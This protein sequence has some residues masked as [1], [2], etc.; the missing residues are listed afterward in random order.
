VAQTLT[1]LVA[2]VTADVPA[3]N[4]VPSSG[5]YTQAVK[6]AVDAYSLRNPIVDTTTLS[7]VADTADY[8]LPSD[9]IVEIRMRA[10]EL[11]DYYGEEWEIKGD[12]TV[13][14]YP[15]PDVAHDYELRYCARH[16]LSGNDYADLTDTD[17]RVLLLYAKSLCLQMKSDKAAD[18]AWE[19]TE[20]EQRV[21]KVKQS[22]AFETRAKKAEA[23]YEKQLTRIPT[24]GRLGL[25]EMPKSGD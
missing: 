2:R 15:T 8:D 21:S 6:D 13:T 16:T 19:Y 11:A 9:F 20:G 23:D 14:F 22:A 3:Y 12:G 5:Q 4:I 17:A 18:D 10:P 7:L 25:T 1:G 24:H